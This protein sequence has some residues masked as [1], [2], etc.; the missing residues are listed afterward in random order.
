[1]SQG[2]WFH[3]GLGLDAMD[4]R[5]IR[6]AIDIPAGSLDEKAKQD[7]LQRVINVCVEYE[8]KH[9]GETEMEVK[10]NEV[11]PGKVL[12]VQPTARR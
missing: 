6:I 10:V 11:E 8:K 2:N 9:A 1:M 3:N 5:Y 4:H 12:N 7:L